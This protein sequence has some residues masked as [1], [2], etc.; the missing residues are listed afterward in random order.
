MCISHVRLGCAVFGGEADQGSMLSSV[1][2]VCVSVGSGVCVRVQSVHSCLCHCSREGCSQDSSALIMG[3]IGY[4][5]VAPPPPQTSHVVL[6]WKDTDSSLTLMCLGKGRTLLKVIP[7]DHLFHL[8]M[9]LT[10]GRS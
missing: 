5:G 6:R 7:R 3:F 8:Q 2:H 4:P 9:K 10:S 1:L